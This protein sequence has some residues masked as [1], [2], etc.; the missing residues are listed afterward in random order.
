MN[1][2]KIAMWMLPLFSTLSISANSSFFSDPFGDDIFKEMM[3]MQ[4][5]MDKM[6]MRMHTRMQ[7][8]NSN[9]LLPVN[10]YKV[11]QK[12]TFVDRGSSYA[13][14]TNIPESKENQIELKIKDG[15][16]FIQA[17]VIHKEEHKSS[18]GYVSS[19]AMRMYQERVTLPKDADI[20]TMKTEY[21][22]G[23]LEI[24]MAKKKLKEVKKITPTME[25]NKSMP[26]KSS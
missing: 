24:T 7:E 12:S 5:E 19:N 6:F 8:R 14:T 25:N 23:K 11:M 3:Q 4:Q 16:L 13:L 20:A 17:K 26:K 10:S 21:V 9:Q 15:V 22:S 18:N 2:K 1:R